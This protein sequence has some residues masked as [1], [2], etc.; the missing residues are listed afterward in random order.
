MGERL[1]AK[2]S[3][4]THNIT[5]SANIAA[6]AKP[7]VQRIEAVGE[8]RSADPVAEVAG[9]EAEVKRLKEEA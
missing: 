1:S 8:V 4:A 3:T 5:N 6:A 9:L 2:A 7:S